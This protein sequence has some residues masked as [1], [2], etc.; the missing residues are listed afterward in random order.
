[1]AKKQ[2]EKS[3]QTERE[4]MAAATELFGSKGFFATTVAEITKKAGYAKGSF[5]RHFDGKDDLVLRIIE[6]KLKQYRNERQVRINGARSLEDVIEVI[7]D[8]LDLIM[9]DR[10]WSR[11]FLEFAIHASRDEELKAKLNEDRYR[12]SNKVFAELLAGH[13]RTGYPLEKVGALN[14]AL[15]EGFL[16]HSILDTGV[17]S[18]E[19][20]REA[21]LTLALARG[22]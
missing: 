18:K 16:I 22:T 19:D 4:L 12:L 15:F 10:N 11:V 20:V 14:T 21:A 17:L 3:K 1:M 6:E 8:F 5:Y 13:A 2:Q 9:E 7:W